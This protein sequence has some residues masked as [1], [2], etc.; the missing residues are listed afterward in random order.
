MLPALFRVG[1]GAVDTLRILARRGSLVRAY[2]VC[3]GAAAIKQQQKT[4]SLQSVAA[5]TRSYGCHRLLL[6]FLLFLSLPMRVVALEIHLDRY[7]HR[8]TPSDPHHSG[9]APPPLLLLPLL[10]LRL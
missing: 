9:P 1:K 8:Q 7:H 5:V 2:S 6:K 3:D 10:H 4:V